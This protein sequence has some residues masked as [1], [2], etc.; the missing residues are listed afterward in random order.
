M[1]G[2]IKI[3]SGTTLSEGRSMAII[4]TDGNHKDRLQRVKQ[5]LADPFDSRMDHRQ[6]P[7]DEILR[8]AD[9]SKKYEDPKRFKVKGDDGTKRYSKEKTWRH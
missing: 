3:E 6:L 8:K 5:A 2:E 7:T 1:N 9:K 4:P